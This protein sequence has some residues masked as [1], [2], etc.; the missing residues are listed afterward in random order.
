MHIS[1][2][3]ELAHQK[4]EVSARPPFQLAPDLTAKTAW[5]HRHVRFQ[6]KLAIGHVQSNRAELAGCGAH[7][8]AAQERL[9]SHISAVPRDHQ[10]SCDCVSPWKRSPWKRSQL[11]PSR[12]ESQMNER[13]E[14]EK[15]LCGTVRWHF[16]SFTDWLLATSLGWRALKSMLRTCLHSISARAHMQDPTFFTTRQ[17][18]FACHSD[19]FH[20]DASCYLW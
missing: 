14:H 17:Q 3:A 4:H 7:R 1:R 5:L 11:S 15:D 20:A 2:T 12:D 19:L 16:L 13:Q 10:S 6:S 9:H 18:L 8:T